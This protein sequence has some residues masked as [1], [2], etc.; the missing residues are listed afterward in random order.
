MNAT[1][2]AM[3]AAFRAGIKPTAEDY[4]K[5][6][7]PILQKVDIPAPSPTPAGMNASASPTIL[8]ISKCYGVSSTYFHRLSSLENLTREDWMEPDLMFRKLLD[9]N[10]SP[11]RA[12]LADPAKR[13]S[14]KQALTR[15]NS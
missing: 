10:H 9:R 1:L 14:I 6:G 15:I 8:E 2:S 12:R 4:A 5:Y 13:K 11:L 7:Q 3:T